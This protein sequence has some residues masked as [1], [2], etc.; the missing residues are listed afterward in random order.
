LRSLYPLALGLA[1][2]WSLTL[3]GCGKGEADALTRA[4][5]ELATKSGA[6]ARSRLKALVQSHPKSGEAR[7]LLGMQLLADG[8]AGAAVIELQRA[9]EFNQP[10]ASVLPVL[11]EAL[12]LSGQS[13]S[14]IDRYA[15]A[16]LPDGPS[17]ARLLAAVAR[18][19]WIQGDAWGAQTSVNRALQSDPN[20]APALR[21]QARLAAAD[22]NMDAALAT[23][24]AVLAADPADHAA[25]NLLG[26][27]RTQRS[28]GDPAALLAFEQ[29]LRIRPEQLH[30]RLAL[31]GLHL[32]RDDLPAAR[33]QWQ[34]LQQ[35]AP[36]NP[37]TAF[38][39]AR[40]AYAA[41]DHGRAREIY[42]GLLRG[43][44]DNFN[45]LL[46]AGQ[47]ELKL[48]A[49]QQ[50]EAQFAKAVALAPANALARCLLAQAQIRLGQAA[51][52]LVTLAPLVEQ[53]DAPADALALAAEA[54]LLA[55]DDRTAS[56]LYRRLAKLEP[57][58]PRLRTI[59]ASALFGKVDDKAMFSALGEIA[60]NDS[61]TSADL[62]LIN[63]HMR[64]GQADAALTAMAALERKRPSDAMSQ[65][66]RGQILVLR[67]DWP[68]ARTSFNQ[69]AALRG[70]YFPAVAALAALDLQQGQP[71]AAR[72]RLTDLLK[73]QPQ[74]SS[75]MLALAELMA[76]QDAAPATV[77]KL[78]EAA[79]KAAPGDAE[80]RTALIFHHLAAGKVDAALGAAQAAGAALP[81]NIDLLALLG[82]CQS[83]V[84]QSAQALA[85]YGKIIN[86]LPRSPRGH[87]GQADAYLADHQLDS[88]QRSIERA[89]EL[90]PG[91]PE[92]QVRAVE[93]AWQRQQ[94]DAAIEIARRMQVA[95][96]DQASGWLV[97]GE[98]ELRRGRWDAAA[99]VL[100]KAL[101]KLAPG[102]AA[103]KLHT[104]LV[105]GG[106]SAEAR[107]LAERWLQRHPRDAHFL[108]QLGDS[109][110]A[111]GDITRAVT[112]YEAVLAIDPD[113][114]PALNNLAML[115]LQQQQPGATELAE[116]AVRTAPDQAALLDT[117]ARAH[118]ADDDL[119]EAVAVQRRA[120]ALAPKAGELR[121]GLARYYLAAGDKA[122]AKT[123]LD[124]LVRADQ[125]FA[126]H[127]E[128]LRMSQA[129]APVLPGR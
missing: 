55:G 14:V 53:A 90:S 54:D 41:G 6:E 40:L 116:R 113:H 15:G 62:A 100:R 7:A 99:G 122:L 98:I 64:R 81:N 19:Q 34:G 105:R 92:A 88:A 107:A 12:L 32:A 9:L 125:R 60:A 68:A 77:L 70:G 80:A 3:A 75:A 5:A 117:L 45:L 102:Q 95:H 94:P 73:I 35:T 24:E 2:L 52:A 128:V 112:Y 20:S 67:Q 10:E 123:E 104:A 58:E 84:N 66:L 114:A 16:N 51:R 59:V 18:A 118:A 74:N 29:S 121:L 27:L 127:D 78:I 48:R 79:V 37:N 86:L 111:Q 82:H 36:K 56:A 26:D 97:E 31:I 85:S 21:V 39:E 47:N 22:G 76:Q 44:P 110:Q 57:T 103:I 69:A 65:Q 115:R 1:L 106:K 124:N 38:A 101:A 25:W 11:A 61:G 49:D 72:Q 46:A 93:V 109:A 63:A 89:L 28:D 8:D 42:Q 43:L 50:A 4:K 108:F 13:R 87:L 33:S 23:L 30:P 126:Q 119:D 129:L 91:L 71:D 120:V 83:R 17:Q 96:P